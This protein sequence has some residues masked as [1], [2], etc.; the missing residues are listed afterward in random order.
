VGLT[1]PDGH[2]DHGTQPHRV[3]RLDAGF[4]LVQ[5]GNQG[6]QVGE[7]AHSLQVAEPGQPLEAQRVQIVA[8]EER[9]VEVRT[10]DD[11]RLPVVEQVAL[12]NG[13]DHQ[14]VLARL[15]G[16]PLARGDQ[17]AQR[18]LGVVGIVD[19]GGDHRPLGLEP[20]GQCVQ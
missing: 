13:L 17:Q 11:A 15:S 16:G 14:G 7:L 2:G 19:V 3:R 8:G 18:G 10:H 1:R 5:L 20:S 6:D 4:A 9:Q 12:A